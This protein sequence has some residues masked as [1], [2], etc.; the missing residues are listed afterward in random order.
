[1]KFPKA[2]L[3]AMLRDAG[4]ALKSDDPGMLP[5]Q[6]FLVLEKPGAGA[7]TANWSAVERR[8]SVSKP[9]VKPGPEAR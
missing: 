6:T 2:T 4:F 5:Y 3:T 1:V 8:R 9:D 7:S